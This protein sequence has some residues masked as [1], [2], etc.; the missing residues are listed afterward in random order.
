MRYLVDTANRV[1]VGDTIQHDGQMLDVVGI[2]QVDDPNMVDLHMVD[3]QATIRQVTT[4]RFWGGEYVTQSRADDEPNYRAPN[5][6]FHDPAAN[7]TGSLAIVTIIRYIS[8]NSSVPLSE[9][10]GEQIGTVAQVDDTTYSLT[11]DHG[12]EIGRIE[13]VYH[14]ESTRT[15]QLIQGWVQSQGRR[16]WSAWCVT[17]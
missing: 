15:G 7:R 14:V 9:P 13:A 17:V 5:Q 6:V 3:P 10:V 12:A 11:D 16:Q 2:T 8:G 4:L 1:A